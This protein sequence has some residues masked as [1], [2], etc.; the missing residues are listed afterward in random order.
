MVNVLHTV[1]VLHKVAVQV[2]IHFAFH[3]YRVANTGKTGTGTGMG[4]SVYTHAWMVH[5]TTTIHLL[6]M[7]AQLR[8][9]TVWEW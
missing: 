9:H 3:A 1:T 2:R 6:H 7:T 5:R 8:I 4:T